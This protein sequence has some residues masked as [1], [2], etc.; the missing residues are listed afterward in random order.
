VLRER[1]QLARRDGVP[2]DRVLLRE[3]G[4]HVLDE[5]ARDRGRK[6]E[7]L[8]AFHDFVSTIPGQSKPEYLETYQRIVFAI[9][10]RS[11]QFAARHAYREEN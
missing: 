10:R 2:L 3:V 1:V 7:W 4:A 8:E 11:F 9:A 6:I 5:G